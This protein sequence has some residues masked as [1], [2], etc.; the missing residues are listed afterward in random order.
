ME[1][2]VVLQGGLVNVYGTNFGQ[3]VSTLTVTVNDEPAEIVDVAPTQLVLRAPD[4]RGSY[5]VKIANPEGEAT[6]AR[7]MEVVGDTAF[8][9][10]GEFVIGKGLLGKVYDLGCYDWGCRMPDFDTMGE[11]Q[12]TIT[13]CQLDVPTHRFE[14]GFPGVDNTLL[15]WF[16]IR[17][18]AGSMCRIAVPINSR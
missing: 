5:E 10:D 1:P 3:W 12:S 8:C 14:E 18:T 4:T 6:C 7:T 15:E 2:T 17:F 13:A 16:T 9:P 11:P